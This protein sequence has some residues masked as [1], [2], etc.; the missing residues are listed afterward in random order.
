M[1]GEYGISLNDSCIFQGTQ[2]TPNGRNIKVKRNAK[3][4]GNFLKNIDLFGQTL[5][6]VVNKDE[7][8]VTTRF[9][10]LLTVIFVVATMM[11]FVEQVSI[12]HSMNLTAFYTSE[13]LI[14]TEWFGQQ[15]M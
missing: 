12:M 6:F 13:K 3:N 15:S 14:D 10:G 8:A 2:I 7:P 9:G 11:Y 5:S 4:V 1:A